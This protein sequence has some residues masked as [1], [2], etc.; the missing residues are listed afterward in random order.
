M[1]S[2]WLLCFIYNSQ[3]Q[4]APAVSSLSLDFPSDLHLSASSVFGL[5]EDLAST[6]K[7]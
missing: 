3:S 7:Q 5:D 4:N 1:G 2:L 6:P